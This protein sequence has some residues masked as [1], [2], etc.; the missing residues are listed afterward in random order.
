V[1]N[2]C[3]SYLIWAVTVWEWGNPSLGACQRTVT[4]TVPVVAVLAVVST[5]TVGGLTTVPGRAALT[6]SSHVV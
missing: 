6:F 2:K 3:V 4:V 5:T 1:A